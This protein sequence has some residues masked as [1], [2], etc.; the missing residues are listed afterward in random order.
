MDIITT[1]ECLPTDVYNH[2]DLKLSDLIKLA[3]TTK[4][5]RELI[6]NSNIKIN[7]VNTYSSH[8]KTWARFLLSIKLN[9][10]NLCHIH[11]FVNIR[12]LDLTGTNIVDV[13]ALGEVYNLDLTNTNVVDFSA[14]SG[15]LNLIK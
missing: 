12:N 1:L 6:L 13:S 3:N 14:L 11:L 2:F 9:N 15:V 8:M 10:D 5:M 7:G 4:N